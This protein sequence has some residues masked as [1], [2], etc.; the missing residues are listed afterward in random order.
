MSIANNPGS[1]GL[2]DIENEFG[3]MQ[4]MQSYQNQGN[5]R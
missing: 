1:I 4:S 3:N 5:S 2:G